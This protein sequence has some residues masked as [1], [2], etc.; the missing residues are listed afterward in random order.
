MKAA[1]LHD[2]H[3]FR[4]EEIQ[5]PEIKHDECLISVKA[6]GVCHSE[7]HQWDEKIAVLQYPRF[8]GHEVAGTVVKV[9]DSVKHFKSG[10]SVAVWVEGKGYAEQI[11]V[12]ENCIFHL[13]NDIPF[14]NAMAEPISCTTN[15]VLRTNVTLG[16]VIAIVGTGFM[17]L[18]L[19]QELKLCGPN[20]IIAI[21]VRE[22]V[23]NLAQN[24][25]ADV[26]INSS[27]ENVVE[28]IKELTNGAGV[29]ISFEVG[30]VQA[31]LDLASEICRMEGKLV[32]FGYHPGKRFI[33][34]LGYWNWMAFD[35]I[36]A[37]FRDKNTILDGTRLGMKL[38]NTGKIKMRPLITH[39]YKLDEINEAFR[40]AKE[41]PQGFVKAV[42]AME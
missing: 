12:K 27:K 1:L 31:T 17:G 36:N 2:A 37:H 34:D 6:C 29:D 10:D 16:D 7:I 20:Q 28:R 19:L 23:L 24:L 5:L 13:S 4:I 8:I 14:V 15:A 11:A 18:I 3:D 30:G 21:D 35:I 32:L 26:L 38:L 25:G 40:T 22:D 33:K 39:S 9:G 41:K 42:I